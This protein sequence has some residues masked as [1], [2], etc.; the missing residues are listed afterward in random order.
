ME[1]YSLDS[2][3]PMYIRTYF[4]CMIVHDGILAI[5]RIQYSQG[6]TTHTFH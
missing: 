5:A 6:Q 2:H 1:S 4:Y 3:I